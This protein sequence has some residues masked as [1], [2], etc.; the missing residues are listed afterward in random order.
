MKVIKF[1]KHYSKLEDRLFTTIRRYDR[2]KTGELVAIRTP[3]KQFYATILHKFRAII[4]ELD[5]K[6]LYY[7]T[8]LSDLTEVFDLFNSFYKNPITPFDSM[9]VLI[10]RRKD[11]G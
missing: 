10:L 4:G 1:S 7:D 8:D 11:N 5:P 3:K 6:L 9:T 2:Y